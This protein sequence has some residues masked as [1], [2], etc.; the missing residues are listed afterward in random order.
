MAS[1]SELSLDCKPHS[2]SLL[3]KS[4]GE[5]ADQTQKLEEVL[6]R[7]EDERLKI[8]AFKRELPLCMQL[9]SNAVEASRQQLQAYRANQGP[10]PVL[11]E[12]IP[13]KNSSSE[14]SD[15]SQNMSDKSNW[16]TTAQLWSTGNET[17]PQTTVTTKT[18]QKETDVGGFNI[19]SPKLG[20]DTKQRNGGA[21]L[22]FSKD[23]NS[24][25]IPT[26]RSLPDLALASTDNKVIMEDN[27]KCSDI[28]E[29]G[30]RRDNNIPAN[31]KVGIETVKGGSN[32]TEGQTNSIN[33]TSNSNQTHRKARRCWSPDLHRRFVNALQ[34][35]GGSQVATPKQIRELMKVDGL[36]NDEVKSHLQVSLSLFPS[37]FR[38]ARACMDQIL[39]YFSNLT[40]AT[41]QYILHI[42]YKEDQNANKSLMMF[43]FFSFF[44]TF[45]HIQK[46]RLHTRRPSP[47]PQAP[48]GGTPQLVVLGG[49]W[50]P[51][52]Y[53]TAAAAAHGGTPTL[54][55]HPSSHA[56]PHFCAA[57]PV[58]QD[59]YTS[60]PPSGMPPLPPPHH[61]LHHHTFQQHHNHNQ[62][63]VY[64]A[65]SQGQSSPESDIRGAGDRSESI[66]DGKSESSSWK[67]ESGENGNVGDQRKGL[68]SLREDGEE[69][70]GSEITL[71]F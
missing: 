25:Q 62:L 64:K 61:Q 19:I 2:Y 28:N 18:N 53:A 47:S 56:P 50:V 26:L 55:H 3:L 14:N 12:F 52:E 38:H 60:A 67:G 69:S 31:N 66:E 68:A 16:M 51:P 34:M 43:Y 33:T 23:R 9:L 41:V 20:L 22:P 6:A 35:L 71:K 30:S 32:S 37:E 48:G 44:L 1:S 42:R 10:R 45:V 63:H 58:P 54:Y 11:E 7:L 15:K 70:N 46:F 49:I 24:C 13:L 36:T 59:F 27:Q 57:S 17:K 29:N 40:L 5:Q 65:T 8:D 4:F 21:F 39:S